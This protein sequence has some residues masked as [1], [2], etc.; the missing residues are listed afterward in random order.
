MRGEIT[1]QPS[2][3]GKYD[4]HFTESISSGQVQL[5]ATVHW[6]KTIHDCCRSTHVSSPGRL[7][8]LLNGQPIDVMPAVIYFH[9]VL[10]VLLSPQIK[11]MASH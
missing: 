1:L 10:S 2:G 4:D 6:R 3:P 5:F 7:H 11:R 9:G 8:Y